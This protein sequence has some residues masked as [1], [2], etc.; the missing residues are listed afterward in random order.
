L[1]GAVVVNQPESWSAFTACALSAISASGW[2]GFASRNYV[3]AVQDGLESG[4][5]VDASVNL[6]WVANS[7]SIDAI[8]T[9][10]LINIVNK[11]WLANIT[12]V[13]GT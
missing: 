7:A 1:F 8:D 10:F 5:A 12:R 3:V 2:A 9:F 13:G 6:G 4:T 11:T